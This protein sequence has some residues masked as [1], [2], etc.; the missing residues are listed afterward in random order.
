MLEAGIERQLNFQC[1]ATVLGDKAQQIAQLAPGT[2]L[3]IQ[4]FIAPRRKNSMR[5]VVHIQDY[6]ISPNNVS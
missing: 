5:F 1:D 4:G 2:T 6:S 3:C